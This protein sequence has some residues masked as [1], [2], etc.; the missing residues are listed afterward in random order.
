MRVEEVMTQD[1]KTCRPDDSLSRAAQ[2]MWD[3]DCGCVP[4]VDAA[5]KAVGMITDRDICM[6]AYTRGQVLSEM[7]VASVCSPRVV[8][9]D[10]GESVG[11]AERLMREYK[12]RRLPAVDRQGRV[13]GIV[14]MNDLARKCAGSGRGNADTE[15]VVRT[16][17]AIGTPGAQAIA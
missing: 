7:T 8:G 15:G 6:A 13:V 1:T 5:G 12:V 17:A 14:S 10:P 9:V 4:V 3:G 16:L 11:S 2:I